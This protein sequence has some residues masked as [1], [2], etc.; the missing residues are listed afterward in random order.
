[1][2]GRILTLVPLLA[3]LFASV[4]SQTEKSARSG[5]NWPSFRGAN[6]N[7]VAEGY[8]LPAT[9]DLERLE[10]IRWQTPIP[11]L[12]LS[13]PIV[14]DN[15]IFVSSAI[16]GQKTEGLKAGLY[17][18]IKSAEDDS[19]HRWVVYCIDKRN[20]KILWEKTAHTGVPKIRR[21][22]KST[23]AN[24]TMVT[25]GKR[26]LAFFG[27]EGLYCYNMNGR[28]LWAKDL[29]VLDSAFFVAPA[30]QWEFG[31]S[32]V[33]HENMVIVQCDVLNGSF[34]AAFNLED[35]AEVWRTA[36]EEVPTWGTP[37]VYTSAGNAQIV[38]NGFK[39]IGGYDA[40]TGKEIWRM[41]G[42]GDIPVPTPVVFGDLAFITNA[43]GKMAPIYAIR[44]SATGDISLQ[45]DESSNAHVAWVAT[46]DGSYMST[47]IVYQD[48]LYNCRW[49]GVLGCY[50]PATGNRL[51]QERLGAGMTAFTA[52]PV[53][54]DGKI[55]IAGEDGD[56]YII[57][58]GPTY[59]L[60]AKNS[61]GEVCLATPAISA[62][63]IF[64][65]TQ[66]RLV[67]IAQNK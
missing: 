36:R 17:G 7:G 67:A 19:V 47:P 35:G 64:F 29:G 20:G 23:H 63:A 38:V 62:G 56:V 8:A 9:W 13:S 24:S 15:R 48:R 32:P 40:R 2:T 11:G 59:R 49:N 27:S 46:R 45:E 4:S 12:G 58:A 41:R 65:R 43:H 39:H 55:Y 3:L 66:S 10:N 60:L 34:L 6:A 28:L 53:A 22:P 30:A 50:T 14:W 25:D 21:H 57:E 26:V 42:G 18:D 52:S 37:A 1:M 44:L 33:I 51:Y 61:L 16:S 54:G 5:S 31:S